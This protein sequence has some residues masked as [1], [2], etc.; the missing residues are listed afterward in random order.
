MASNLDA[1]RATIEAR[2]SGSWNAGA[3]PIAWAGVDFTPPDGAWIEPRILF[4]DGFELSMQGPSGARNEVVGVL[5]CNLYVKPGT[6]QGALNV[7]ADTWRNLFNRVE[8]SGVRFGVPSAP[9]AVPSRKEG[10]AWLQVNV[11]VSFTVQEL[12]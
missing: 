10:Q 8:V 12:V 4:G 3:A 9:K 7:L 11:T 5:S 1:A 2:I 6:G